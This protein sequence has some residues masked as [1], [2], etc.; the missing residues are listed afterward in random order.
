MNI[1]VFVKRIPDT[2]SKIRIN[3]E[4]N[5]IVEEGL[6]FVLNPYDEY[7]VEE[8]LRLREGNGGKV[9]V[10]SVGP[11]EALVVLKK[12][13]AMAAFLSQIKGDSKNSCFSIQFLSQW[14][15]HTLLF[16]FCILVPFVLLYYS[17]RILDLYK[18]VSY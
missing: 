4:T 1:F 6:N 12:C 8:A 11:E 13:L 10:I 3:Q 14:P 2:E 16:R 18:K 7:A 9:T 17:L 15:M 5:R